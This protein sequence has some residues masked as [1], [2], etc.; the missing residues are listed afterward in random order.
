MP[1]FRVVTRFGSAHAAIGDLEIELGMLRHQPKNR[2]RVLHW[3]RSDSQDAEAALR[4]GNA[5]GE[6]TR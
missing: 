1:K 3:M 2:R 6:S 5:Y 4:H